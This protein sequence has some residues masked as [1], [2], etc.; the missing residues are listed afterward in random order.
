M[1][2]PTDQQR[3][4]SGT[5]K[6]RFGIVPTDS[7]AAGLAWAD[8]RKRC[9]FNTE[10]DDMDDSELQLAGLNAEIE[11]WAEIAEEMEGVDNERHAGA[12][13][14]MSRLQAQIIPTMYAQN[15]ALRAELER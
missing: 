12:L 1:V 5:A 8:G 4:S 14:Q 6:S 9:A 7:V 13:G 2:V 11:L 10:E 3:L 15:A